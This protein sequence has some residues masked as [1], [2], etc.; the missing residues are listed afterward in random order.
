MS[1][2][3]GGDTSFDD[4]YSDPS[5]GTGGGFGASF[6]S[7]VSGIGGL[8]NGIAGGVGQLGSAAGDQAEAQAF[9][10]ES[11]QYKTQQQQ[12]T[13][14]A[15]YAAGEIPVE[16]EL[17]K[18]Q[19]FQSARQLAQT[20]GTLQAQA[21]AQGLNYASGSAAQLVRANAQ[22][23]ALAQ[24]LIGV[25][26]A[27]Q[28][29]VYRAQETSDQFAATEAGQA[30]QEAQYNSQAASDAASATQISGALNI[31][32]GIGSLLGKLLP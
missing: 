13:E 8:V 27:Q 14:A 16:A 19:Q 20:Q 15:G 28:E 4:G 7:I 11:Q 24:G 25:Q 22:Q 18:I 2:A 30:S 12:Y 21:G 1:G 23:G 17:T 10:V 6:G 3:P 5:S 32:S 31:L 26:G 29:Q 9:Q